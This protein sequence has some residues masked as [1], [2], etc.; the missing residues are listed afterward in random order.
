MGM[1]VGGTEYNQ[2]G[3]TLLGHFPAGSSHVLHQTRNGDL[4]V[5][6]LHA[7]APVCLHAENRRLDLTSLGKR[8]RLAG[9]NIF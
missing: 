8:E 9:R 7:F 2:K 3:E 6:R 5:Q 4:W 1:L